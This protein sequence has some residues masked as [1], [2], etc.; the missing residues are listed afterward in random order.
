MSSNASSETNSLSFSDAL[1]EARIEGDDTQSI[2]MDSTESK[3]KR[4]RKSL[5]T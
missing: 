4:S 1:N 2:V 5:P 3:M